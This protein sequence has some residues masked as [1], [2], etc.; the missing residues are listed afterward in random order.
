MVD[1]KLQ[2]WLLE[3][4]TWPSLRSDSPL[5]KRIK[6]AL[7]EDCLTL[8]G[9][10]QP[11]RTGSVASPSAAKKR[12]CDDMSDDDN[13]DDK[14]E[15]DEDDQDD[16]AAT[17]ANMAP[18]TA[19]AAFDDSA[20]EIVIDAHEESLRVGG[21]RRIFPPADAGKHDYSV[22]FEKESFGNVVL[23]KWNEAGCDAAL[24]QAQKKRFAR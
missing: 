8:L 2:P 18:I 4:N 22:F 15:D 17:L 23:R 14:D 7:V 20:W 1:D 5:D 6:H 11:L 21:L 12:G 3:V 10:Q 24:L 13:N 9:L 19:V 16:V